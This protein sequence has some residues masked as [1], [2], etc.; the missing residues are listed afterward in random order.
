[1]PSEPIISP[2]SS[3]RS[4]VGCIPDEIGDTGGN[5]SDA[6]LHCSLQ[7]RFLCVLT[8]LI[9]VSWAIGNNYFE[10]P[11]QV[12]TCVLLAGIALIA[13][14]I[15]G[16]PQCPKFALGYAL[17]VGLATRYGAH[18]MGGSDVLVGTEEA[19]STLAS[20]ENPY[21]HVFRNTI[22][23]GGNFA[24]FPGNLYFYALAKHLF[25]SILG[26]ELLASILI[27]FALVLFAFVIGPAAASLMTS[28]YATNSFLLVRACDGSN[29]TSLALLILIGVLALS[30]SELRQLAPIVRRGL[31]VLSAVFIAWALAFKLSAALYVPFIVYHRIA[32]GKRS[33]RYPTLVASLAIAMC[34]PFILW[35]PSAITL[36]LYKQLFLLHGDV[37]GLNA[38]NLL[39]SF[40]PDLGASLRPLMPYVEGIVSASTLILLLRRRPRS[41]GH[42]ILSGSLL[43]FA[44][45]FFARFATSAYYTPF[46]DLGLLGCFLVFTPAAIR[47]H[48]VV[49]E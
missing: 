2:Q 36:N 25:G 15:K 3:T 28:L 10:R 42:A 48:G 24:Y 47:P 22:P 34:L 9:G 6:I 38:W 43:T 4:G 20:G 45:L 39:S 18:Y 41:I 12:H 23:P 49:S 17:L 16:D 33:W 37:Y 26:V 40:R 29:D 8:A 11:D 13:I 7:Q 32:F 21:G 30:L 31:I 44:T 27:T 14:V 35:S 46:L 19:L 1:M 5:S